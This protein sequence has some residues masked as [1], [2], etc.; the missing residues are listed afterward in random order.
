MEVSNYCLEILSSNFSFILAFVYS[1]SGRL[2]PATELIFSLDN[3]FYIHEL[4]WN[5]IIVFEA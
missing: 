1:I 3:P 4:P 5:L 2:N